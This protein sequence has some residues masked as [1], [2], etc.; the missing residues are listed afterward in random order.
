ME[1]ILDGHLENF[2]LFLTYLSYLISLVAAVPSLLDYVLMSMEASR[3][4]LEDST[5]PGSG[6]ASGATRRFISMQRNFDDE[7]IEF[8]ALVAEGEL[9]TATLN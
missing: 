8:L 5:E 4:R 1:D 9:A 3:R 2:A 6:P 7:T